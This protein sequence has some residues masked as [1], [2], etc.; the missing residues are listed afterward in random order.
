MSIV[1]RAKDILLD[2]KGAWPRIEAEPA[3]VQ[4]I[5]VPYVVALAAISALAGFIGLSVFGVGG[6][7]M[8]FRIPV[9]AGLTNMV[10]GFILSLAM[11]FVM[12]LVADA[13]APTF[14]G[15]KNQINA[16]KLMAYGSTAGLLGGIFAIIPAA[17]LLGLLAALY[18][19][20]LI[21]TGLPVLM[22]CAQEKT[23]AYTTVL[24]VCGI[25]VAVVMAWVSSLFDGGMHRGMSM[26]GMG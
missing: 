21:Y 6:F 13:L 25:V 5:Y 8:S 2:P 7:G 22:K 12:A 4:S 24:V 9:F 11:V 19:I 17:S 3:T 18:S 26:G 23:L 1:Q 20:Y 10:F 15:Q 14:G 16:L